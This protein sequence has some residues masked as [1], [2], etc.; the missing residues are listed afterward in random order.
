MHRLLV[1]GLN[2]T[3]APLEVRET[4][5]FDEQQAADALRLLREKFPDA[6]AVLL[7]TCNRTEMYVARSVHGHPREEE[8]IEFLAS[9]HGLAPAN[10]L[11][12]FYRKTDKAAAAHLFAVA[13]SLDS[14]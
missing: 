13:S 6:E 3:T 2:H 1:V 4:L 12:H 8:M 10:L 9:F 7:S 14:M 5:V 11:S